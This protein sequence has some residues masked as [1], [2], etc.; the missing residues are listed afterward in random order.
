MNSKLLPGL[1]AAL[2]VASPALAFE[3]F[4]VKDIRVEGI[5]RTE[6]G[7][8]FS[9]LP[10]KVGERFSDEKA[11]QAIKALFATGF[12]KDVRIEVDKDV[13][14]VVLDERP[15][16]AQVDFVGIKEFDKDALKKGLKEVGLAESR[17]FD[18]AVLERAEQELKRQ[19]LS[20]GLYG[21]QITTTVTPL[22]RN[23]VGVNFNV[24]EGDAAKI[25]QISVIGNQVFKE[26]ELLELFSLTTPGWMTWY[27]KSDQYSK[28]KLSADIETL[29]SYY[30][31]RGY[32]DFT[33]DSTQVSITPDKKDI[34]ITLSIT[35]GEKY[36][37]SDVK[38]AGNMVVPE[39]ELQKL[40]K[41][42]AGD[43]F[44]R[45]NVT[46]T[47]KAITDRLGNAGYAFANVNAA[48]EVDKA[49]RTVAFTVFVD[50]GRRVYVRKINFAGNAR[51]RDEVIRREMRQMEGAWYDGEALNRSKVRLD[52]LGY[53]DEVTIETPAVPGSTDQVD[54]NFTVKERATGNLML[55][56]GFSSSEKV[57]LS[58]SISQQNLF[59]TGNAMT[60]QVN[61]GRINKTIALSFTNPYWTIDGVSIGWDLYQRNVDPTSLSV[62]TYKSSSIGAGIR[63]G[64]PI[65]EDDRI[66]FG[67]AVDQTSIKVYDSSPSPYVGFV[68]T[69]GDTAK[70]LLATIGWSRDRRDSFVY[71]T[72]GVYQRASVEIAT[73]VFDMRYIRANYQHQYWIPFGGGYALM[74]NGDVGY[75]HGY[76]GKELPFYKNFY[77]GG[78]G[79][80]RG[81]QQSTLGPHYT[82]SSGYVRALGGNRR[83]IGN[84]EYYFPMPGSGKDKSMRLSL[85]A[86][87]GNVW[88]ADEKV[89]A[90]D[91]RYS[92]GLA[93]SW[94]SPVGPL[95]FSLGNALKKKEGDKTQKFQ[96]QLGTV[97]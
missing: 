55:G 21:V 34:Y 70:S 35:E 66:N 40:V 86:D 82:D 92:A 37:V 84:A 27:S 67:L 47:T 49:K 1:I 97:F 56:A 43:T 28:Q 23:R 15:A 48:P 59:G 39:E 14:V 4:V 3:P 73:P 8:V 88:G 5:Q 9:Y 18:R 31:N 42:K 53:F 19:Y 7:T 87:V 25:R 76:D 78:I 13:I 52:R 89:Q 91:L 50:P 26:K 44:V 65:A 54:A 85:F 51:T 36:T 75:A 68:N 79:S 81:Y 93:F 30:L 17:I 69:F 83:V 72:S 10:V 38:L 6:A 96:F 33:V 45:D 29:R 77:A 41:L 11:S 80:V 46:A 74:L 2:F 90:S 61:T 60:L 32:L 95:K 12:F 62:A 20:K 24:V 57:I 63:F 22:E 71:P 58:A 94:S 64:Y 16:I